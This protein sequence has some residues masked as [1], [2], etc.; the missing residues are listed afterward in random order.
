MLLRAWR[1]ENGAESGEGAGPAGA[2]G[3]AGQPKAATE[4][5]TVA[6]TAPTAPAEAPK[7]QPK[8]IVRR[9]SE[10]PKVVSATER[11]GLAA[12]LDS[13]RRD[14]EA[15][16]KIATQTSAELLDERW[17]RALHDAKV[18]PQYRQHVRGEL[19]KADPKFDP[20]SDAGK[21]AI[22]AWLEP[23]GAFKVQAAP[24]EDP[25]S[26]WVRKATPKDGKSN[27]PPQAL[28]NIVSNLVR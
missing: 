28:R 18:L 5:T 3:G 22:D 15:T 14:A 12:E 9:S 17:D 23:R 6:P 25:V 13:V 7:A 27:I 8:V 16:K 2:G 20:K 10:P 24:I 21:A 19:L 26:E 11:K 1:L 4:P